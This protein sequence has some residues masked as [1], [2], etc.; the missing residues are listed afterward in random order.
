MNTPA[1]ALIATAITALTVTACGGISETEEAYNSCIAN[2]VAEALTYP[3]TY[4]GPRNAKWP[5][6]SE[7]TVTEFDSGIIEFRGTVM[8]QS[9][10]C[11]TI[12]GTDTFQSIWN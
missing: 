2:E 4:E 10:T 3:D 1:K 7:V 9:W 12:P 11:R 5:G 6:L 8:G